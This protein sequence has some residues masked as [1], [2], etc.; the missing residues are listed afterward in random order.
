MTYD[1]FGGLCP[2]AF[3]AV[4]YNATAASYI[5]PPDNGFQLT[6]TDTPIDGTTTLP[7]GALLDRFGSEYGSFTSPYGAPYMQRALPP[8]NL[9]TPMT[10]PT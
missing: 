1:R 9:D 4:W 10:S 5:Y 6:T 2:G 8:S 7:V 3:L